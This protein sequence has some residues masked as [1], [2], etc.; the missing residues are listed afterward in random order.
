MR[1]SV[2]RDFAAVGV[3]QIRVVV[4]LGAGEPDDPGPWTVVRIP[5]PGGEDGLIDLARLADYTVL[6]APETTGIL[7]RLARKLEQAGARSLGCSAEAIE[8]AGDKWRL[9]Q[10][11]RERGIPT[12]ESHLI[13]A[14]GAIPSD[15]PFPAVLKPID[16]A[17]SVDTYFLS[18]PGCLK[19][20]RGVNFDAVLQPFCT[21]VPMSASFLVP[22]EGTPR[23]IATGRQRMKVEDGRFQYLGGVIPSSCPAAL[24]VLHSALSVV[25]GLAGF[26]G[27]DFVWDAE[28]RS[29]TVLEIN[30]RVTTSHVGLTRH[31]APGRLARAWLAVCK[32]QGYEHER[33]ASL[34]DEAGN[35]PCVEF[36]VQEDAWPEILG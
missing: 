36:D 15:A 14:G 23:L 31:L 5:Y 7:A 6:I 9:T 13:R 26:V 12:P 22:G 16:G 24:P 4:T 3:P 35:G 32:V 33:Q 29:A 17:G 25:P 30:P 19:D 10:R 21:G 18:E 1:Q 28:R 11:F 27:V 34:A 20:L 2:A 8:L